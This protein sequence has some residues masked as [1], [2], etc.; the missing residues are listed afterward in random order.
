VIRHIK[1]LWALREGL[2]FQLGLW[3][4]AIGIC[5]TLLS[6]LRELER[7]DALKAE[8]AVPTIDTRNMPL[9]KEDYLA[10]RERVGRA[11]AET[12][13]KFVASDD[14]LTVKA[15]KLDDYTT[16]RMAL[17]DVML[18]MPGA[19][20][21]VKSMCA[22][23]KCSDGAYSAS[24]TAIVRSFAVGSSTTTA[25]ALAAPAPAAAQ[26]ETGAAQPGPA[27]PGAAQK[28]PAR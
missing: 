10:V 21:T 28:V 4:L 20:W 6:S 23:E 27:Q 2:A 17:A 18:S 19:V 25:A 24:V 16:W 22:G 1:R 3:S 5:L 12:R 13:V 9:R 11:H 8:L 15:E 7:A 26:G 14:A